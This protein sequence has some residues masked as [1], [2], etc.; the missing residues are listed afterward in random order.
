MAYNTDLTADGGKPIT[1]KTVL[2]WLSVFFGVMFIANGFFV[3]F[4]LS[5]FSGLDHPSSYKAGRD[6]GTVVEAASAQQAR[7]WTVAGDV[8][9]RGTAVQVVITGEDKSGAPI[10]GVEAD[11]VLKHPA[12]RGL[13]VFVQLQETETGRYVGSAEGVQ[14]GEYTFALTLRDQSGPLY[15][16]RNRITLP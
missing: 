14:S 5:T 12:D 6:F 9:R 11:A 1:G 10:H 13:D 8:S 7:G 4:A 3:Y 2:V 15:Q 16:S